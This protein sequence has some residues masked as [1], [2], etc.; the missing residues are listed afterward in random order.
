[1]DDKHLH[2]C[3]YIYMATNS[4]SNNTTATL[5][6]SLRYYS[7]ASSLSVSLSLCLSLSLSL[8]PSLSL[9]LL[10]PAL[11]SQTPKKIKYTQVVEQSINQSNHI[12][13]V[14]QTC[15]PPLPFH[16][17]TFLLPSSSATSNATFAT[18]SSRY[19]FHAISFPNTNPP[20][21][22]P[23]E[24]NLVSTYLFSSSSNMSMYVIF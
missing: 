21:S 16:W 11:S 6:D 20:L 10:S 19:L 18:P 15:P 1:M 5:L 22:L 17:T 13:S 14:N 2:S 4:N 8:S 12:K 9:I 23:T 24:P 3:V 7:T